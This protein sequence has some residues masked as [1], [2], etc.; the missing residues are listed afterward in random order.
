MEKEYLPIYE[1]YGMGLTVW[2]P[3]ASGL[4][5][6]KYNDGVPKDSR[7]ARFPGLK[8]HLEENG[9]LSRKNLEKVGKLANVAKELETGLP[10]LALAWVLKN[11]NVSSVILGVSRVEQLEENLKALEVK[12]K[13]TDEVMKKIESI[14]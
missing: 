8:K 14:I 7:L 11:E 3:L 12:E 10:Q 1:K 13:L 2:S 6:G 5:T 9:M 4:L